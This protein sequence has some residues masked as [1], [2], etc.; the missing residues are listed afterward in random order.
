MKILLVWPNKDSFGFK[1]IGISLLS[2]IAKSVGWDVKLFDTTEI[3]FGFTSGHKQGEDIK[4]FKPVDLPKKK[5][6]DLNLE[7][8]RVLEEYQPD[9]IGI[10]VLSDEHRIAGQISSVA[11]TLYPDIPI[12]W[13]GKY[14]T[15]KPD[16]TLDNYDVDFICVG[17]GLGAFREFLENFD[18]DLYNIRNIWSQHSRTD[19]RKLDP[20]LDKLPYLDWFIFNEKQ[21][22]KPFDGK[23]YRG[24]DH[25]LNW[26]CPH[27][28]SYC[29]NDYYHKLYNNKYTVRRYGIDRIIE[30]LK[31]LKDRWKL[32]F[33][34]FHDEDFL[35]RPNLKELSE[36]YKEIGLPFVIMTNAKSVT[37][38]KVKL[39]KDMNCVS[40][41]MGIETGDPELRRTLLKRVD[42]DEDIIRAFS[43]FNEYGIRTVSFTMLGIPF[44]TRET[45]EK[46]IDLNRRAGAQFPDF[47]FFYPFEGT[48]LRDVSIREGFFSDNG[49]YERN[50]PALHFKNLSESELIEMGNAFVLHVK[51][52]ES[53][54]PMIRRSETRDNEG[55]RLRKELIEI[56]DGY[57]N[58]NCSS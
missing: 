14:P 29:I 41:S 13:G 24:G 30:E 11:R 21:F 4:L 17:E 34:K 36:A 28:C 56:Y 7:F 43:L 26:G 49:V 10:S 45:Y 54:E 48:E 1:P 46:T 31:Y 35:L 27:H 44:E 57:F 15:L 52:P 39:L 16:Y 32:E 19:I 5:N 47:G 33:F 6:L 37:E 42:K 51:L 38:N 23:I 40:V 22:L 3:D 50:K 53:Y 20:N 2:A 58:S 55:D 12:I 8:A 18:G 9:C 25:M